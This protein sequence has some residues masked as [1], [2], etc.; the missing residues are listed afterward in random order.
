MYICWW[1]AH[2]PFQLNIPRV[3]EPNEL[4]PSIDEVVGNEGDALG[5]GRLPKGGE[6]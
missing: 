3:L 5:E 1:E 2:R 6:D 4:A